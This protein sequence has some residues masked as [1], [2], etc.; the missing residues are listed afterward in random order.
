MFPGKKRDV[1]GT[2]TEDIATF[3][4]PFSILREMVE[5]S[6]NPVEEFT[7][8]KK[9]LFHAFHMIPIPV[10]HA[11]RAGFLCTLQDHLMCWD[12]TAQAAAD[13]ICKTVYGVTFNEMLI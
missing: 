6:A 5:S 4:D 2:W 13:K 11:H 7:R 10:N 1:D 12:P 3:S 8:I 9:D